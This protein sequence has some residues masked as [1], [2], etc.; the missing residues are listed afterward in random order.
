MKKRNITTIALFVMI[1]L[2]LSFGGSM[3]FAADAVPA[4]MTPEL[5]SKLENVRKQKAQRIT[6]AQREAAAQELKERTLKLHQTQQITPQPVQAA[7]EP[8]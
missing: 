1:A 6:A 8:K 3:A 5:A 4:S 7:P 2:L